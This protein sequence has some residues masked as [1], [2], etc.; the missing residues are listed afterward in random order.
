MFWCYVLIVL[1]LIAWN[2]SIHKNNNKLITKHTAYSREQS[3]NR[4][5]IT[6]TEKNNNIFEKY[7]CIMW[8]RHMCKI[9]MQLLHAYIYLILSSPPPYRRIILHSMDKTITF[10][11]SPSDILYE[12]IFERIVSAYIRSLMFRFCMAAW[13]FSKH[14][15]IFV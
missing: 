1:T 15:E 10:C 9:W 6:T 8:F 2:D 11:K 4:K 12:T 14:L 5:E 13:S 3:T 7:Q